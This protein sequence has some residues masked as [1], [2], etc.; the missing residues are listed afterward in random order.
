MPSPQ[1]IQTKLEQS[2]KVTEDYRTVPDLIISDPA[3]AGSGQI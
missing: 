3:G 1:A 2:P